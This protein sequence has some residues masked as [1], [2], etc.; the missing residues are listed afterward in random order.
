[1]D[2]PIIEEEGTEDL[3]NDSPRKSLVS[4]KRSFTSPKRSFTS[5]KKS[6][7]SP[8]KSLISPSSSKKSPMKP[9]KKTPSEDKAKPSSMKGKA[10]SKL[11]KSFSRFTFNKR[12]SKQPCDEPIDEP[13]ES[14]VIETAVRA[15]SVVLEKGSTDAV[16]L[17]S[18]S[19]VLLINGLNGKRNKS[20]ETVRKDVDATAKF[21]VN[22]L[23]KGS[24]KPE[25]VSSTKRFLSSKG[26]VVVE[27]EELSKTELLTKTNLY[28][29]DEKVTPETPKKVDVVVEK[30]ELPKTELLTKAS[31]TPKKVVPEV[32]QMEK[33]SLEKGNL[34]TNNQ[35]SS[36]WK[37]NVINKNKES[38]SFTL[39]KHDTEK[40]SLNEVKDEQRDAPFDVKK[41]SYISPAHMEGGRGRVEKG[42]YADDDTREK[43]EDNKFDFKNE[44]SPLKSKIKAYREKRSEPYRERKSE[45]IK[46]S[47]KESKKSIKSKSMVTNNKKDKALN[48]VLHSLNLT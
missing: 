42:I 35:L 26:Y 34:K 44:A 21:I 48:Q 10:S 13:I 43:P 19:A 29:T 27:K 30:K 45:Q 1:L 31:L 6:I 33:S 9:P 5:P 41:R 24:T 14:E 16:C 2:L 47:P 46:R 40:K 25:V 23:R 36:P 28:S 18:V 12:K 20:N 3:E 32:K 17:Q 11:K 15:A 4:P 37:E 39:A 7:T 8:K 22:A 38:S